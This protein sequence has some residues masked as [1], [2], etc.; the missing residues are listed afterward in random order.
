M[1]NIRPNCITLIK[2]YHSI[3]KMN[4]QLNTSS[5]NIKPT[6]KQSTFPQDLKIKM[7][8][9]PENNCRVPLFD[10]PDKYMDCPKCMF[11][12]VVGTH[13]CTRCNNTKR[14]PNPNYKQRPDYRL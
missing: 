8:N 1:K 11:L 12:M 10:G 13:Y 3:L 6:M 14:V 9:R 4:N 7:V 2:S 5:S